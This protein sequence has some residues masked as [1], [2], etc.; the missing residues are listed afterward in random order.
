M[1][2]E[3]DRVLRD[4]LVE[5]QE[6][7]EQLDHEFVA[8]VEHDPD[9]TEL[10]NDIFRTIH[11]IKGRAG[12][13]NL[14]HLEQIAHCTE[15]VLAK[16]R[17]HSLTLTPGIITTLLCAVDAIKSI[18][19]LLEEIGAEGEL[20]IQEILMEL[21]QAAEGRRQKAAWF[22]TAVSSAAETPEICQDIASPVPGAMLHA[23]FHGDSSSHAM[24]NNNTTVLHDPGLPEQG[25]HVITPVEDQRIH[26]DVGILD[27]LMNLTGELVLARNRVV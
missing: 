12:F 19:L 13:L 26:V 17:D 9:N 14:I 4:F 20:K 23:E 16:L 27:Q 21:K 7:L 2:K 22:Q 24:E 25:N 8:L 15:N 5:S 6:N 11:T 1:T 3:I 10:L 18:L